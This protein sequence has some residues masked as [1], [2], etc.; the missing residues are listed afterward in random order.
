[1]FGLG[2]LLSYALNTA[3]FLFLRRNVGADDRI[4]YAVSLTV[5]SVVS[6]SWSYFVNFKTSRSLRSAL[7]RYLTAVGVGYVLNY[8]L[9]QIGLSFWWE[10]PK[11]VILVVMVLIAGLKFLAYHLWVFPQHR[12]LEPLP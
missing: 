1:M 8:V 4:A 11:L 12:Q 3:I 7:T 10:K 9:V 2:G 5:T 6:Y